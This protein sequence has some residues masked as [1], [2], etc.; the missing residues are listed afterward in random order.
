MFEKN[1]RDFSIFYDNDRNTFSLHIGTWYHGDLSISDVL[2]FLN[3]PN[4]P[5]EI[6]LNFENEL[7]KYN[8]LIENKTEL[9]KDI[10]NNGLNPYSIMNI[11][12]LDDDINNLYNEEEPESNWL[13][14]D[15]DKAIEFIDSYKYEVIEII[16]N[17][18]NII[19]MYY[20]LNEFKETIKNDIQDN[21][22]ELTTKLY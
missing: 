18:D 16:N 7:M 4:A 10:E 21:L 13:C 20:S 15:N 19:D 2:M 17:N 12:D 5:N 22:F 11:D 8:N 3:M 6:K 14:L 9:I 1:E